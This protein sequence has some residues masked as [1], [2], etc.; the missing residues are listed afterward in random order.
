M[1]T[2]ARGVDQGRL[3]AP[4]GE[5]QAADRLDIVVVG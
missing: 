2:A 4:P 1:G 5:R 3:P